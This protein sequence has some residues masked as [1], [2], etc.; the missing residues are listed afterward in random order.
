MTDEKTNGVLHPP[1][2][3]L[4]CDRGP[5]STSPKRTQISDDM[6]SDKRVATRVS[7]N[8]RLQTRFV[9]CLFDVDSQNYSVYI[10]LANAFA[11]MELQHTLHGC[12]ASKI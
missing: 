11:T 3:P 10:T 9:K 5:T 8:P 1:C 6:S 7:P 2:L 4:L 12:K